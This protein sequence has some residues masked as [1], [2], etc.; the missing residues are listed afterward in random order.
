MQSWPAL[1]RVDKLLPQ[2]HSKL[3]DAF[4]QARGLSASGLLF[5]EKLLAPERCPPIERDFSE[6]VGWD[7]PDLPATLSTGRRGYMP[8]GWDARSGSERDPWQERSG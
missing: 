4:A 7:R 6:M 1:M 8:P 5:G 3:E 2:N